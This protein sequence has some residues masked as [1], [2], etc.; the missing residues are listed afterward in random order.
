M[1]NLLAR[2][3]L[4][5]RVA[6]MEVQLDRVAVLPTPAHSQIS[7][8]SNSSTRTPLMATAVSA[9]Q[10]GINAGGPESINRPGRSHVKQGAS[11]KGNLSSGGG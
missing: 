11:G 9:D 6:E 7:P 4:P 8:G 3:R 2:G 10:A 5:R 1:P